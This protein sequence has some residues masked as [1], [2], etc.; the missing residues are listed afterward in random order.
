[1]SEVLGVFAR[2][3]LDL[4][5]FWFAPAVND[6]TGCGFR[7]VRNPDG[8]GTAVGDTYL[9]VKISTPD[10]ISTHAYRSADGRLSLVLLNKLQGSARMVKVQLAHSVPEQDAMAWRYTDA[11]PFKLIDERV[12]VNADTL[13]VKLPAISGLRVDIRP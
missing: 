3:G 7:L 5:Y 1:M 8:K 9:P 11:E 10:D 4:A 6:A 13:E 2:E 12:H